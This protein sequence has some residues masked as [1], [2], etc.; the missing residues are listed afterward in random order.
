[1]KEEQNINIRIAS[2][3][4]IAMTIRRSDEEIIRRAERDVNELFKA[5]CSRFPG[6][7]EAEIMGMTAFQF[8]R[9]YHVQRAENEATAATLADFEKELDALLTQSMQAPQA[10]PILPPKG[11]TTKKTEA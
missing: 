11:G 7:S 5:L 2:Q 6:R 8:A 9:Y 3:S 4:P 1:M 10:P